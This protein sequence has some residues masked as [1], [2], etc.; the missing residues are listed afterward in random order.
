MGKWLAKAFQWL[1]KHPEVADV[2][3]DAVKAGKKKG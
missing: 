3:I 1:L 2:V